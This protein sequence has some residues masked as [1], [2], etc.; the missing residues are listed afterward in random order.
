FYPSTQ[1][2]AS[3]TDHA[4]RSVHLEL[5][6]PGLSASNPLDA[7]GEA[8]NSDRMA[9]ARLSVLLALPLQAR[10]RSLESQRTTS[11]I[12]H[13][14]AQRKR[15][16]GSGAYSGRVAQAWVQRDQTNSSQVSCSVP[17][18]TSTWLAYILAQPHARCRRDRH[19]CRYLFIFSSAL[20]NGHSRPRAQEEI[21]RGGDRASYA[22]LAFKRGFAGICGRPKT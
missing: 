12:D 5:A 8:G 19:V 9:P 16:L 1:A 18:G 17:S 13:S 2:K 20:R 21:A 10:T 6:I 11:P 3:T 7:T 4:C 14:D 15:W 22:G